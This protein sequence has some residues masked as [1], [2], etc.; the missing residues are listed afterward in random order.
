MRIFLA[1]YIFMFG[2][3]FASFF[4]V[5]G[6]RVKDNVSILRR[7]HCPKC[8]H[9]LRLLD[10]I[11]LLGFIIDRGKCHYCGCKIHIKYFLIEVAGGLMFM[12][13][14]LQFG[15]TLEFVIS[16]VIFSFMMIIFVTMYEHQWLFYKLSLVVIPI[17][18]ALIIAEVIIDDASIYYNFLS[19]LLM[20]FISV[21]CSIEN[22]DNLKLI[23]I[24]MCIGFALNVYLACTVFILLLL[25]FLIAKIIRKQI[26][27]I[28]PMCI[29]SVVAILYGDYLI[30]F[31]N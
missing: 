4:N 10:V 23:P 21:I 6:I 3:L 2:A 7:S 24:A 29:L 8:D 27:I 30:G 1:I 11:P 18:A 14:Y 20:G 22:K 12:L 15:L 19:V 17:M 13:A 28:Y 9:P 25:A 16:I 5:V 26:S 31:L